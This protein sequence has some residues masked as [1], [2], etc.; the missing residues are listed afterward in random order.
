MR[1]S[2]IVHTTRNILISLGVLVFVY[3]G[4]T[5]YETVSTQVAY[6]PVALTI[7]TTATTADNTAA[8]ADSIITTPTKEVKEVPKP[9]A[10]IVPEKSP[11]A[12]RGEVVRITHPY[13][14]PPQNSEIVNAATRSALVNI[15][16]I[17]QNNDLSSIS[18]SGIIIDS[19]GI[20][21][22]NAHIAQY[23]LL[24]EDPRLKITCRIRTGSP[25]RTAWHAQV[26]YMPSLWVTAHAHEI[27][28]PEPASTGENDYALL[29]IDRPLSDMKLPDTFPAITPDVR[30]GI[31]FVGDEVLVASYPAG[32]LGPLEAQHDLG[33][34]STITTI[35]QLYTFNTNMYADALSL[36]GVIVA[37]HGSSGGAVVNV[38]GKL[39]GLIVTSSQGITTAERDLRA[40][41]MAHID[42]SI[43]GETNGGL[44]DMLSGNAEAKT[45][46]FSSAQAPLLREKF[47]SAITIPR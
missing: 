16:C 12:A 41:S 3:T 44:T 35:K 11:V 46:E 17:Q 14:T 39:V 9:T 31:G 10:I 38:W 29:F 26:M 1:Y 5:A 28:S 7:L 45:K 18:G 47:L 42:R 21:L 32:F 8:V 43:R 20:I 33:A 36:G 23:V 30:E 15:V 13:E 22:T 24:S 34:V 27:R 2:A 37:Q 6:N 40:L 4:I 25:A 19:Q